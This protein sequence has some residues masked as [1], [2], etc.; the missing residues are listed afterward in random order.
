[1]AEGVTGTVVDGRRPGPVGRAVAE[2]LADP[3]RAAAMGAAGRRR[4]EAEL[5]WEAVVAKL[6]KLLDEAAGARAS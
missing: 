2:L 6:E 1:M 4:V 5:S 3:Q